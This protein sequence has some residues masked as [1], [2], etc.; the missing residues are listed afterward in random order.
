MAG[1][2]RSSQWDPVLIIAQI[3]TMQCLFYVGLGTCVAVIDFILGYNRSLSQLFLYQT[4][5]LRD[6][7]G[8]LLMLASVLNSF[9]G[10]V[11]LWYVVQRTR[12]CWDF[13]TT[14]YVIH[15]CLCI[16]VNGSLASTA[17]WWLTTVIAAIITTVLAESL[18]MRTEMKLIPLNVPSKVDL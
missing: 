18:C 5:N 13:A 2:F 1:Q 4:L 15:T 3:I 8:K 7:Q 10:G 6:T 16:V 9:I 11:G 12:Q 14:M 17:S